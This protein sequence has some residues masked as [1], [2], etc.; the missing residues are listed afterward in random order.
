VKRWHED[1]DLMLTRM[2]LERAK[3]GV[4]PD[5]RDASICHCL[6][7]IGVV[8]KRK[9]YG[10]RRPRCGLCHPDKLFTPKARAA[11]RRRAIDFDLRAA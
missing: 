5:V 3:H 6:L 7:G 1:R 8:R 11:T 9:P 10:C 2:K 4:G